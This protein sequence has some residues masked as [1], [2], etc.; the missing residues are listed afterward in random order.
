MSDIPRLFLPDF[1]TIAVIGCSPPSW[2]CQ[3]AL[4]EK[5]VPREDVWLDFAAGEHKTP[6]MLARNPRGTVPVLEHDGRLVHE[7]LAIL[8]YIDRTWPVPVLVP[9]RTR[10]AALTRMHE[11]AYVKDAGMALFAWLMRTAPA[12]RTPEGLAPRVTVFWRELQRWEAYVAAHDHVAGKHLTLADL[13]VYPYIATAKR[14]GL[15]LSALPALDDWRAR[16]RRRSSVIRTWPEPWAP[17]EAD[18]PLA[19]LSGS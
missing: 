1:Q 4:E 14:L 8:D 5:S 16:M 10:A 18:Q 12:D 6:D 15:D 17:E 13:L 9:P 3:L 2:A 19:G 11:A 7:T